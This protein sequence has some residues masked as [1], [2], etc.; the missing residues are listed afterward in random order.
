MIFAAPL[1]GGPAPPLDRLPLVPEL[2]DPAYVATDFVRSLP[3]VDASLLLCNVAD[4][5]HGR[6]GH[7][8][9][10]FDAFV[11]GSSGEGG[12]MEVAEG[13][14]PEG[15]V[16]SIVGE[17]VVAPT[18]P[19][20]PSAVARLTFQAPTHA[21]WARHGG[22][23]S[24]KAKFI[25]CFWA[26]PTGVG[27]STL[28]VRYVRSVATW[29]PTPRWLLAMGLNKFLDQDTYLLATQQPEL[30]AAEAEAARAAAAA[31]ATGSPPPP[32]PP[33]FRSRHVFV[34]PTEAFV[35]AVTRWLE[36][37]LPS[38]PGR[39][40]RLAAGAFPRSPPPRSVVLD[41]ATTHAALAPS[42]AT[43]ARVGGRVAAVAKIVAVVAAAGAAGALGAGRG[44]AAA[45]PWVALAV[46]AAAI[47]MIGGHV[48]AA[49]TY[50]YDREA[51]GRDLE[52]IAKLVP[53]LEGGKVKG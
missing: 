18:T 3:G 30:L 2:E 14:E 38:V 47:A 1:P 9:T 23:G 16:S 15:W 45:A 24:E 12:R 17:T 22:G 51:A 34:T 28:F 32:T 11:V 41:R 26:V 43:A 8:T 42:S 37:A 33:L 50:Q 48:A 27:R 29:V 52:R 4:P 5:D 40:D 36:A 19:T 7:Q 20:T 25:A 39:A 46:V 44:G 10:S 13:R 6:A 49:F 21:R 53:E 31:T 35:L